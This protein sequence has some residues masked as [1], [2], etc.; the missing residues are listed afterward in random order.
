MAV[1]SAPSQEDLMTSAQ[2]QP[3][4]DLDDLDVV[5]HLDDLDVVAEVPSLDSSFTYER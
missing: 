5:A 1:R 2:D 4:A 3:M